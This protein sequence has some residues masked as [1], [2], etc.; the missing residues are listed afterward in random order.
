MSTLGYKRPQKFN[1]GEKIL[2][3]IVALGY[4][5]FM[6]ALIFA[7]LFALA[8]FQQD[9]GDGGVDKTDVMFARE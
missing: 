2:E 8:N 3:A 5:I 4:L 7:A 1:L 9:D 6:G